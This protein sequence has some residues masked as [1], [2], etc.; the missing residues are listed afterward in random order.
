MLSKLNRSGK[1]DDDNIDDAMEAF[2]KALWNT[3]NEPFQ[4]LV[5]WKKLR[6]HPK[7][8]GALSDDNDL[9]R[10]RETKERESDG[11]ESDDLHGA[12]LLTSGGR[13]PEGKK[14]VKLSKIKKEHHLQIFGETVQPL[15]EN[16][17]AMALS[18]ARKADALEY[19]AQMNASKLYSEDKGAT[20]EE[21][22]KY[23]ALLRKKA[24][25]KLEKG[26]NC[27]VQYYM[28]SIC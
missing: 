9:K 28:F 21:C 15:V 27:S 5:C 23:F 20:P 12:E 7:W 17:K 22:Q 13:R 8:G 19:I 6:L 3:K 4:Y 11:S 10:K 16:S 25:M 2:K 18:M 24:Y 1:T 14:K 26:N